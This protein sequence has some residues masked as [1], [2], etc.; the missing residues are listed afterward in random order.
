[1][2]AAVWAAL[3]GGFGLVFVSA[4]HRMVPFF[5]AAGLPG[6]AAWRPRAVLVALVALVAVQAPFAALEALGPLPA[7]LLFVRGAIEWLGALLLFWLS[8]RWGLRQS[9]SI[10]LLAML[11]MGFF[12]L[13]VA[14]ALGGV[15]HLLLAFSGGSLSL[16]LAPV[17]AFTMGFLGSTLLAMATRLACGQHGRAVVADRWVW[18]MFWVLQLGV[19][20][21]VFAALWPLAGTHL[22]LLAVQCWLAAMG[23]WAWRT[24]RWMLQ[25]R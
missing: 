10:R 16:G 5:S 6:D 12:W 1:V 24:G 23:A 2:R 7:A 4:A 19:M 8:L 13:A 9:L 18:V 20:S 22:T 25:A 17:H 14:F 15:S 3:W 21:R 11:H